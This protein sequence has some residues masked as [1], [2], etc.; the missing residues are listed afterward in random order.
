MAEGRVE[1]NPQC[2]VSIARIISFQFKD[3][4]QGEHEQDCFETDVGKAT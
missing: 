2:K 4:K 3:F 1:N